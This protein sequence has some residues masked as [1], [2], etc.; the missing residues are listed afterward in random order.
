MYR[1][2]GVI[3]EVGG[4]L[5]LW[6]GGGKVDKIEM[7][8]KWCVKFILDGVNWFKMSFLLWGLKYLFKNR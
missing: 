1:K 8:L 2:S 4:M 6:C 5:F 3:K 7:F